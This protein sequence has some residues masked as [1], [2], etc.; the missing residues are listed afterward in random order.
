MSERRVKDLG[1]HARA[2]GWWTRDRVRGGVRGSR[3]ER[4]K[5]ERRVRHIKGARF[6]RDGDEYQV[7]PES[8]FTTRRQPAPHNTE[9]EG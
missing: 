3:P 6:M 7:W 5:G 8:R 9:N 2:G 1:I 4:R